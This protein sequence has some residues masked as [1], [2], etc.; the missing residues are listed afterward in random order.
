MSKVN[1]NLSAAGAIL[2]FTSSTQQNIE[3][4][5]ADA[6]NYKVTSRPDEIVLR[7][8]LMQ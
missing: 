2:I 8:I 5:C 1:A 3:L 4:F 6:I 7:Q